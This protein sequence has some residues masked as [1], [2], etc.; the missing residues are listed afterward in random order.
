MT[1]MIIIYSV[2][3]SC[4]INLKI[5]LDFALKY[6]QFQNNCKALAIICVR[7]LRV[8]ASSSSRQR[9]LKGRR[10]EFWAQHPG[11]GRAIEKLLTHQRSTMRGVD[12]AGAPCMEMQMRTPTGSCTLARARALRLA[13]DKSKDK[14]PAWSPQ[15]QKQ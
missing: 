15:T 8:L 3:S 4:K 2:L 11:I 1:L 10:H 5:T 6:Q 14:A 13:G 12:G 7:R 9:A